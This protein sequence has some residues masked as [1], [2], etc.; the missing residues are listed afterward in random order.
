MTDTSIT[1][2]SDDA[3]PAPTVASDSSTK[4][5]PATH[6]YM[7]PSK[8][9]FQYIDSGDEF[10]ELTPEDL[11]A[12]IMECGIP[13]LDLIVKM[14]RGYQKGNPV[15]VLSKAIGIAACDADRVTI[16][17]G[18]GGRPLP[19]NFMFCLVGPSGLG[20][21]I[22]L[23]APIV[24]ATPLRGY[25]PVT[26]A[27][28]E[29]LIAEF[30]EQVPS[31]DGKGTET[32][33]HDEPVWVSWGEI[34]AFAAKSGNAGST[35]DAIM[36]SLWTGEAAGDSSISR[37]KS[38][39]GCRVEE[40]S[41]RFVMYVGAQPDHA[42]ALLEDQTGGTLQRLLWLPIPDDDAPETTAAVNEVKR[43]LEKSLGDPPMSL[44]LTPP[45]L[46]VWGP[47]AGVDVDQAV[48]DIMTENRSR[49]LR[50]GGTAIDP[51]DAHRDNLRTRL[52]AVFAGWRAGMGNRAVIDLDAWYWAGCFLEYSRRTR[53]VC[54]DAAHA[55]KMGDARE[56]GRTD[57]ERFFARATHLGMKEEKKKAR[58]RRK[59]LG[60]AESISED[61]PNEPAS[62]S[63]LRCYLNKPERPYFQ[64]EMKYLTAV[65]ALIETRVGK[66]NRYPLGDTDMVTAV[67]FAEDSLD[68]K[69]KEG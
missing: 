2:N 30:F 69:A 18:I 64:D 27:S 25:H 49:L 39:I 4:K 1:Q 53:V 50:S 20:K 17:T 63:E 41:Y 54:T 10:H 28:G 47:V 15:A 66:A 23:D 55:K 36:R 65:G 22:T 46:A 61:R 40:L 38:G 24:M 21:G 52:A 6:F 7:K 32:Q 29:A 13:L 34:D 12:E 37:M 16:A 59:I 8:V 56:A 43:A 68:E 5:P 44:Q 19:L 48:L 62:W 11:H 31:A 35:L 26:P 33:R 42:G 58:I 9:K 51:L 60:K 67:M 14:A 3:I 45:T 57:A